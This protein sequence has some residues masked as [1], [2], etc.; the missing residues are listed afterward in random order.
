[1]LPPIDYL[2]LLFAMAESGSDSVHPE[3]TFQIAPSSG[4][5]AAHVTHVVQNKALLQVFFTAK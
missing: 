1:M 3:D 5:L 4:M 2:F